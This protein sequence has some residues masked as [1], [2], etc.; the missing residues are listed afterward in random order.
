MPPGASDGVTVSA[1]V[2][3]GV[4]VGVAGRGVAVMKGVLVG[5]GVGSTAFRDLRQAASKSA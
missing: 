4:G 5:S 1:A 3:N 2:D